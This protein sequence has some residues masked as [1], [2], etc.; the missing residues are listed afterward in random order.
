MSFAY[1]AS[2]WK[3]LT[4][5]RLPMAVPALFASLRIGCP[6]AV[7]GA[8]LAE[9]LASGRGLGYLMLSSTTQSAYDQLWAATAV[10]TVAGVLAYTV[11]DTA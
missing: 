6:G 3:F 8:L 9:W 11:T 5:V 7:L 2:R 4:K 10:V 1:D